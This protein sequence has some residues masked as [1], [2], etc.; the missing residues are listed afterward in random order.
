MSNY[1]D[2]WSRADEI[3][4]GIEER[5][6]GV[7]AAFEAHLDE[8]YEQGVDY[9]DLT[10]SEKDELRYRFEEDYAEEQRNAYY[11]DG[12]DDY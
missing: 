8:L 4:A 10:D 3:A 5:Y 1:P 6:P 7:E 12:D 2:G 9:E 11:G